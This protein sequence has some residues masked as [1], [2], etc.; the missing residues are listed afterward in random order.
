MEDDG[1]VVRFRLP[2]ELRETVSVGSAEPR[3]TRRE[4]I[5][6]GPL[7]IT[8]VAAEGDSAAF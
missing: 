3:P 7:A 6:F 4:R 8:G 1:V 5:L 2:P